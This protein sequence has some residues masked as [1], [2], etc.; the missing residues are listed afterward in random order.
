[1]KT[2][3]FLFFSIFFF[4]CKQI[5]PVYSAA[6]A[7]SEKDTAA[8]NADVRMCAS[9]PTVAD[10]Y[11]PLFHT[12]VFIRTEDTQLADKIETQ[13]VQLHKLFD[14]YHYYYADNSQ[15]TVKNLKII[16]DYIAVG[17]SLSVD[18]VLA[19]ILT[20]SIRIMKLTDGNFNIFLE[21]VLNLY[22]G[23][24]SSFPVENTDPDS[25]EIINALR[26]V[27]SA[28][29]AEK[30]LV[31]NGNTL[32]FNPFNGGYTYKINLGAIAKGYAAQK[33]HEAF[34]DSEYMLSLGS[35]TIVASGKTYRIGV[36]SS[37]YKT[38]ALIQIELPSGMALSTSGTGNN[39]Y[40][41]AG[42]PDTVRCHILDPHTG[43][44]NNYYWTVIILSDNAA[45]TD[46][47]S[48]A[49]FNVADRSEIL[50]IISNVEAAYNC[51]VEA[52]FV[53]DSSRENKTV[54]LLM[55]EGFEPFIRQDYKGIGID[56][57]EILN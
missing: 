30:C 40:L 34:P 42:S 53:K 48:T 35:S 46:A 7:S 39:Y 4:S 19:D 23:K 8:V 49:L 54:S 20:D 31:R 29:E 28:S 6:P 17:K 13:L 52:C 43:Y 10:E 1:M 14:Q 55:T 32:A 11:I 25:A 26:S 44:S 37:Y 47:L 41:L 57:T 3:I 36:A 27:P 56:A 2:L 22:A 18:P 38:L 16:N 45:I 50:K 21:P 24:F 33:I 9:V 12:N 5:K 15:G 51:S